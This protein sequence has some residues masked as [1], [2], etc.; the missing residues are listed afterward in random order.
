MKIFIDSANIDE[1]QEA[2]SWGIVEGVTTNPTLIKKAVEYFKKKGTSFTM[3]EYIFRLLETAG[4]GHPVSLEVVGTT[5]E[6]MLREARILFEKFNGIKENVV[7]KIPVNP[8]VSEDGG[9]HFNG[10]KVIKKLAEENI[11]VNCTLVMTPNQALLSAK[12]G[13]R[14]VSPFAGRIDDYLRVRAGIPFKKEDYYPVEG[15]TINN[16]VLN[17]DGIVSGVDLVQ[18]I[19]E[20]FENYYFDTEIIAASVRNARQ[21]REL[22][23]VGADIATIPFEVIKQMVQHYKT[24]EGMENFISDTISEYRDIFK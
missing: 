22:A 11:P 9:G 5:Y 20:I 24:F 21:V 7:I 17:D 2:F 4:F 23:Q 10:L 13:A 3:E 6:E 18:N 8:E 12:A 15:L 1:I 14:Y 16:I 19:K